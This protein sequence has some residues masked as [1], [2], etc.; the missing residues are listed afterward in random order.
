VCKCENLFND[1]DHVIVC[2]NAFKKS[3]IMFAKV[4]YRAEVPCIDLDISLES[5]MFTLNVMI[6]SEP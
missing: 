5:F 4:V 3:A 6:S 2:W 1:N